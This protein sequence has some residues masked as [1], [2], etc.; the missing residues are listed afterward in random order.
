METRDQNPPSHFI[1]GKPVEAGGMIDF[2]ENPAAGFM[3]ALGPEPPSP[4]SLSCL[5]QCLVLFPTCLLLE[6]AHSRHLPW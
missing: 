4:N 3:V 5:F 6:E 1:E 2:A